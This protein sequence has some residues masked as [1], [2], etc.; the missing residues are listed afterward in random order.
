MELLAAAQGLYFFAR[1]GEEYLLNVN[2]VYAS[3]TLLLQPDE[4]ARYLDEGTSY[5]DR[6]AEHYSSH[7]R[8]AIERQVARRIPAE[9]TRRWRI[10]QGLPVYDEATNSWVTVRQDEA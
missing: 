4:V 2:G 9:L 10:E 6:L 1:D 7:E 3:H 5:I 8:V